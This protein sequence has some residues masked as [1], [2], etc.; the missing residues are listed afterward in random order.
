MAYFLDHQR[1]VKRIIS[2]LLKMNYKYLAQEPFAKNLFY[3][4]KFWRQKDYAL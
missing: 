3:G 4:Q 1:K 2:L